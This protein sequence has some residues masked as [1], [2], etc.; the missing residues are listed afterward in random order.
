MKNMPVSETLS[1]APR[2][3]RAEIQMLKKAG[4]DAESEA[5]GID[6]F[7]DNSEIRTEVLTTPFSTP[8][9]DPAISCCP[10][11][12][13][14]GG[15]IGVLRAAILAQEPGEYDLK[16]RQL[17][18][19]LQQ[20]K[21]YAQIETSAQGVLRLR[22]LVENNSEYINR[23]SAAELYRILNRAA[24][25]TTSESKI[26]RNFALSQRR[27][28]KLGI[29]NFIEA[30]GDVRPYRV[31]AQIDPKGFAER[32]LDTEFKHPVTCEVLPIA[33]VLYLHDE[34]FSSVK[35][36]EDETK[37]FTLGL[38]KLSGNLPEKLRGRLIL[39]R[40]RDESQEDPESQAST[41]SGTR[42]HEITHVIFS[43]FFKQMEMLSL[44][45]T[46][47]ALAKCE[48]KQDC[49]QAISRFFDSFVEKARNE[50]AAYFTESGFNL[51]FSFV[52][53]FLHSLN[54]ELAYFAELSLYGNPNSGKL[55]YFDEPSIDQEACS[56][57]LR[58]LR[59]RE[60]ES[61][62]TIRRMQFVT[63]KMN[64]KC[65]QGMLD[66]DQATI[67]LQMTPANK[68]H[69]LAEYAGLDSDLVRSGEAFERHWREIMGSL[70]Q[71]LQQ[72]RQDEDEWWGNMMDTM[73]QL[74]VY[75]PRD[76]IS[77]VC[78]DAVNWRERD[79]DLLV[80]EPL[81]ILIL[82][83]IEVYGLSKT[84]KKEVLQLVD[85]LTEWLEEIVETEC[86]DDSEGP[87]GLEIV[88]QL[89]LDIN[90]SFKHV[91]IQNVDV[92]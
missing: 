44:H 14:A 82:E 28:F 21:L 56:D 48:S 35:G 19:K 30:V 53:R 69:R 61:I 5:A 47:E 34:D 24:F 32:Y 65:Q 71:L 76:L 41:I 8:Y 13:E 10:H 68:L 87:E 88:L 78:K 70:E 55:F 40:Q 15:Y 89:L 73:E 9:S 26:Q 52:F 62:E 59:E 63:R 1:P 23:A 90:K 66:R 36:L 4:T 57:I 60:I 22:N 39:I 6:F 77:F 33:I 20:E 42:T 3:S 51:N 45:D 17:D 74:R 43:E 92:D 72:P 16:L 86:T 29:A 37:L 49:K 18:R 80:I 83:Y 54:R 11:L 84:E 81:L 67:L 85:T 75:L 79:L 58:Y 91:F 25:G 50:L 27:G 12:Y 38:Q 7:K 31:D 64:E 2:L 46:L